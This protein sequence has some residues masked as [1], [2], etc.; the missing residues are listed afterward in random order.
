MPPAA[1]SRA[2]PPPDLAPAETA[3]RDVSAT[4][5]FRNA[6]RRAPVHHHH[7]PRPPALLP[8]FL[9]PL[10]SWPAARRRPCIHV[11]VLVLY[12]DVAPAVVAKLPPRFRT[13]RRRACVPSEVRYTDERPPRRRPAPAAAV[14]V[15]V[16]DHKGR[17]G[18]R[19]PPYPRLLLPSSTAAISPRPGDPRLGDDLNS[20][21]LAHLHFRFRSH[22]HFRWSF[23]FPSFRPPRGRLAASNPL[24]RTTPASG[25]FPSHH[26]DYFPAYRSPS[27]FPLHRRFGYMLVSRRRWFYSNAARSLL[28]PVPPPSVLGLVN[29]TD[30]QHTHLYNFCT[31]AGRRHARHGWGRRRH[32]SG[33]HARIHTR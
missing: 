2:L 6:S 20:H 18:G 3:R 14:A 4:R 11:L 12:V 9:M 29:H 30:A 23:T 27:T 8:S 13:R 1:R 5:M 24:I 17:E 32:V 33:T 19:S 10:R 31:R 15:A 21:I 28:R 16:D 7:H 26:N 22:S 25:F